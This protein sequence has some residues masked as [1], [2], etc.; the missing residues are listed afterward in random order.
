[1]SATSTVFVDVLTLQPDKT[2]EDADRYFETSL[3][4]IERHGIIRLKSYGIFD[5]MRGHAEVN[6]SLVQVWRVDNAD[7]LSSLLIDPEYKAI[8]SIRDS[9]FD[10]AGA[11]GWHC[12]D[13]DTLRNR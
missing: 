9:L 3:P 13:R 4:I 8:W 10:M 11:Q 1:M 12:Y 7:F 5:K 6:P 2:F